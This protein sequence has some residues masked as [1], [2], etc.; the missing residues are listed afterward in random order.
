MRACCSAF[1]EEM[2]SISAASDDMLT[3]WSLAAHEKCLCLRFVTCHHSSE[4]FFHGPAP[5]SSHHR[6]F[7]RLRLPLPV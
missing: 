3:V 7:V 5:R 4:Q 6:L 2:V 1:S